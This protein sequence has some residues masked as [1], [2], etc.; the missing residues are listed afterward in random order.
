MNI[1]T[2]LGRPF[3]HLQELAGRA[4]IAKPLCNRLTNMQ[5]LCLSRLE[6]CWVIVPDEEE[7][8]E[9]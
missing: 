2:S 5:P 9:K 6:Q 1:L 3:A 8:K 4:G 7:G